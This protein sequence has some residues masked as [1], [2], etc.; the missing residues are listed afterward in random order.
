ME[1]V[2]LSIMAHSIISDLEKR[3]GTREVDVTI[4]PQLVAGGDARLLRIMLGNLLDNAWKFTSR[5]EKAQIEFGAT[6]N[7]GET[8]YF[9]RDNGAGF[10][11]NYADKLFGA[12]QRLH[13]MDDFAGTGIGLATVQRIAH[14]HQGRVWAEA[15]PDQGAT[16]YFTLAVG[17][18]EDEA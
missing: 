4:A 1:E 2:D 14:R 6:E 7:D 15:A 11:M 3:N 10:D 13:A 5:R 16:F 18:G 9:V 17:G 8:V 12:F